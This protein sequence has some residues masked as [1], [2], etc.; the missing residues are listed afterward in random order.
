[1]SD[2]QIAFLSGPGFDHTTVI[3]PD[4]ISDVSIGI[5]TAG[6]GSIPFPGLG[7][8]YVQ[9]WAFGIPVGAPL[10][11]GYVSGKLRPAEFTQDVYGQPHV[12]IQGSPQYRSSLALQLARHQK[13]YSTN[14]SCWPDYT[15]DMNSNSWADGLLLS[16]GVSQSAINRYIDALQGE[17]GLIPY[18]ASN[19]SQIVACF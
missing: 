19:G 6:T 8:L 9:L 14:S 10:Q 12:Y 17:S 5:S 16:S 15:K 2:I 3:A 11:A 13:R 18:S 4:G 1:M 7:H